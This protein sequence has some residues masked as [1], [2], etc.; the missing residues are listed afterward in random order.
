MWRI[1]AGGRWAAVIVSA[2]AWAGCSMA[3]AARTPAPPAGAERV[4]DWSVFDQARADQLRRGLT[5]LDRRLPAGESL[6]TQL[7]RLPATASWASLRSHY[8]QQAGWQA[9]PR[10]QASAGPLTPDA[11]VYIDPSGAT[12]LTIAYFGAAPDAV[13]VV[14]RARVAR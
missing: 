10:R 11:Q 12:M 2:M 13:L 7:W 4:A 6:E 1:K 9:D 3:D 5:E 8:D 14:Q